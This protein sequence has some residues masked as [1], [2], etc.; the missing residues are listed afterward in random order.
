MALLGCTD[1]DESKNLKFR[2]QNNVLTEVDSSALPFVS[3]VFKDADTT[4]NYLR[5]KGLLQIDICCSADYDAENIYNVIVPLVKQ[6]DDVSIVAE[7]EALT[8][9]TG[10]YRYRVRFRPLVNS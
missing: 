9:I 2:T 3:F 7:G 10:I 5:N 8:G 6:V 4:G 1:D